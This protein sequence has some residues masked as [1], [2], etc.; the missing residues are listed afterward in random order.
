MYLINVSGFCLSLQNPRLTKKKLSLHQLGF[1]E[2]KKKGFRFLSF[3]YD[4]RGEGEHWGN[5]KF[6]V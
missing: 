6:G 5:E 3:L 4:D 2:K 1:Q